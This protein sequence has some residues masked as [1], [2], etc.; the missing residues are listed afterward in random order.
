MVSLKRKTGPQAALYTTRPQSVLLEPAPV[1]DG[2]TGT[3][4]VDVLT[5]AATQ[6]VPVTT[7]PSSSRPRPAPQHEARHRRTRHYHG[8]H[9]EMKW[10]HFW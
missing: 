8:G 1:P 3:A 5:S 7:E 4:A 2:A 6:L 10:W 9:R